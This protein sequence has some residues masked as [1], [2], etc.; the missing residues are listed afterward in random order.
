MADVIKFSIAIISW[1][2]K[3]IYLSQRVLV[4]CRYT[5]TQQVLQIHELLGI[6][7]VSFDAIPKGRMRFPPLPLV[8][9]QISLI[10]SNYIFDPKI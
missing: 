1:K 7:E 10:S 4:Q 2:M 8:V 5:E 6:P 9:I 3:W